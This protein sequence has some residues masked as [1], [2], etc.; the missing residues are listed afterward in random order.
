M[1]NIDLDDLFCRFPRSNYSDTLIEQLGESINA[2]GGLLRPL[3]VQTLRVGEFEGAVYE[4]VDGAIFYYAAMYAKDNCVLSQWVPCWVVA[5][6]EDLEAALE[7]LEYIA[8]C[9]CDIDEELEIEILA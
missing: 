3:I 1:K 8:T 5:A 6:P 2:V 7:Q 4:V 9:G